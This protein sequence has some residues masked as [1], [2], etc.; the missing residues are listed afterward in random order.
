MLLALGRFAQDVRG[1]T[2]RLDESRNPLGGIDQR[3]RVRARLQSGVV[4][5]AEAIDGRIEAAV[6]R[7][8]ARLALLV[9]A[10]LG[11]DRPTLAPPH[12]RRVRP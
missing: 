12:V 3:S 2:A 5:R 10:A 4:L 11:G 1:V 6:D 9:D 8:A 7:S